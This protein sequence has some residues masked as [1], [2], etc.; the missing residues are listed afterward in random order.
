MRTHR[1]VPVRLAAA[2]SPSPAIAGRLKPRPVRA[3]KQRQLPVQVGFILPVASGAALGAEAQRLHGGRSGRSTDSMGRSVG[4]SVRSLGRM[5]RGAWWGEAMPA[6]GAR[7][8]RAALG[9]STSPCYSN[10]FA[11]RPGSLPNVADRETACS[12]KDGI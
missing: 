1:V 6:R 11:C 3:H 4:R 8:W 10:G 12:Q 2:A 9:P 5:A 7:G